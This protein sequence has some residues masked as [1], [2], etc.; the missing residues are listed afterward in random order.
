MERWVVLFC[1]PLEDSA[2]LRSN[3]V[4]YDGEQLAGQLLR[5]SEKEMF[6]ISTTVRRKP[7]H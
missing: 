3:G 6:L 4:A 1:L 5:W 7:L 2:S